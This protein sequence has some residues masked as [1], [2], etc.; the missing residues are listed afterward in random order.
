MR[1]SKL[2]TTCIFVTTFSLG[3]AAYAEEPT[4]G[5]K[6]ENST[7]KVVDS[8]KKG[9][10]KASDEVCDMVNGKKHCVGKKMKHSMQNTGDKI[11]SKATEIKNEHN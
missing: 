7:N 11:D 1:K 2:I 9:A 4:V 6:V 8:V 10:R 3:I 5:E